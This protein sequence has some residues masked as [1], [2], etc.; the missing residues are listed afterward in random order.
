VIIRDT[1]GFRWP[2]RSMDSYTLFGMIIGLLIGGISVPSGRG[3][4]RLYIS[5]DI[6]GAIPGYCSWDYRQKS[7][8]RRQES[9]KIKEPAGFP[10]FFS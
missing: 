8:K 9:V 2:R 4:S 10:L 5:A 3:C 1:P 6:I 7:V